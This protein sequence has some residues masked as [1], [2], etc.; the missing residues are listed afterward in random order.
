[1]TRA[2]LSRAAVHRIACAVVATE[3]ARLRDPA[4]PAATRGDW[5]EA[6]PIG[7]EGLGLDSM[8]QLGAL[9]ALAEA[10]D[11]DDD[12]LGEGPP[13]TVGAWTDW[14]L[15]AHATGPGRIGVRTSGS[16]GSP[17]LCV[18]AVPDLL[19]EAAVF[20]TRFADRRRVVALVPA[21]HL[22]GLVWTALLPDVLD[23]P[24]AVRTIG[25]PLSLEAGDLV[26]AVPDQWRALSRMMRHW[27]G[28]VIGI[29]SAGPLDDAI[30]AVLLAAGLAGLADIYGASET[31]GIAMRTLPAL[32]YDL[33]P[34]WQLTAADP[35]DWR[36]V[37]CDGRHHDLPDHVARLG[38][39]V[40][41]PVGR[42]D[43]AVQVAGH[44]VWPGRVAGV[45][46]TVE[47]VAD[48]AVR[49]HGNG[50]LKAFVVPHPGQDPARLSARIEQLAANRLADPE[51]P[52]AYRFGTAVPRT[53]MGKLEDWG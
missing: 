16:T 40:I 2:G 20:A 27:P 42:R 4:P 3:M 13:Q 30:A 48:V 7:D 17:R 14:I 28:D 26:V 24:V 39:R 11:L 50:R 19:D 46:R 49:L 45:L 31:G 43:G 18:H 47:G 21:D 41:R 23:I 25:A 44:N 12:T 33:L 5:P 9:G 38:E 29:S 51:R 8:E 1:M 15:R 34:R 35:D 52:K 6:M 22:Y 37:D 10:F 53:A 32:D 36:L